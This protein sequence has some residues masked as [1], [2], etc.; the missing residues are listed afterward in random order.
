MGVFTGEAA[1]NKPPAA[2]AAVEEEPDEGE[3]PQDRTREACWSCDR[4]TCPWPR[5]PG[6]GKELRLGSCTERS[7]RCCGDNM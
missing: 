5:Q 4:S 3:Q 6:A 1:D 2:D 7:C